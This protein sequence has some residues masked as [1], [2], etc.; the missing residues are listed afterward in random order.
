MN[1]KQTPENIILEHVRCIKQQL[2]Y[3]DNIISSSS[4]KVRNI[5]RELLPCCEHISQVSGDFTYAIFQER[6]ECL[7][8]N[9][10]PGNTAV[11]DEFITLLR[12]IK[13]Y[14]LDSIVTAKAQNCDIS[15]LAVDYD[16]IR[17][18]GDNEQ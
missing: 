10:S 18:Y 7:R 16:M 3:F 6:Y 15:K 2:M 17:K 8:E 4:C 1:T 14:I 11:Y 5:I 13:E 9:K 12:D